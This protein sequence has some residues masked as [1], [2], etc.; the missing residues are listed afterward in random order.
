MSQ[1]TAHTVGWI[2][3]R[4]AKRGAEVELP[5]YGGFWRVDEVS[6]FSFDATQLREKQRMDRGTLPSLVGARG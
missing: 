3:E 6:S 5:E 2:E 4:G 1:G